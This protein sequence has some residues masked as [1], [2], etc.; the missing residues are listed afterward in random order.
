MKTRIMR[1]SDGT[2]TAEVAHEMWGPYAT[3]YAIAKG[4]LRTCVSAGDREKYCRH[5]TAEEARET[6]ARYCAA[7]GI[8]AEE[9]K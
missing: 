7:A 1:Q 2:F 4:D 8:G 6:L 9:V 5:A 3:W